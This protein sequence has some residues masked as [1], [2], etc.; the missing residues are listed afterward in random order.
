MPAT[1]RRNTRSRPST[2]R[3]EACP[4]TSRRRPGCSASR[5]ARATPMPGRIWH[6]AVQRHRRRQERNRRRRVFLKAAQGQCAGT[7]PAGPHLCRPA[8]ASGRS[9]RG[10]RWH[11]IA[12]AGGDNDPTSTSS[13]ASMK[14]SERATAESTAKP[15][16]AR[17]NPVGPTPFPTAPAR[18]DQVADRQALTEGAVAG[19]CP[20]E[21]VRRLMAKIS[22]SEVRPGMVIEPRR[23]SM[24]RGQ[25]RAPLSPARAPPTTR[26][27]SRT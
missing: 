2:K 10:D 9:G 3:A 13:C 19:I 20:P 21:N 12:R 18:A 22:G 11:L 6:R 5:R 7:E 26:S 23:R 1:R 17:M 4:R 24:G 25:D 16:I 15:W 14:P 27:S 8:A